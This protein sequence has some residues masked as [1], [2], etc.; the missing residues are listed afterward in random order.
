MAIVN[1][2][3][4]SARGALGKN[5]FRALLTYAAASSTAVVMAKMPPSPTF[6]SRSVCISTALDW[7]LHE[8]GKVSKR[9]LAHD[10]AMLSTY[11]VV[12][13]KSGLREAK[14][15]NSNIRIDDVH[16]FSSSMHSSHTIASIC[17]TPHSVTYLQSARRIGADKAELS[18]TV[19]KNG[20]P[21]MLRKSEITLRYHNVEGASGDPWGGVS[22]SLID[23]TV[24]SILN[25]RG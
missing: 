4:T 11:T 1:H 23:D 13:V 17:K 16:G 22:E 20:I 19:I 7:R 3:A 18:V 21:T 2:A 25:I 8:S 5:I 24:H 12:K 6:N 14:S 9:Q 15:K 10:E